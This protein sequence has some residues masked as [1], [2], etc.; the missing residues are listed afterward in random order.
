MGPEADDLE[1]ELQRN[2]KLRQEL[3]AEARL[4]LL[5]AR[6]AA[7]AEGH[8]VSS[9]PH[10][11]SASRVMR[12]GFDHGK[13]CWSSACCVHRHLADSTAPNQH[14]MTL[15]LGS[16]PEG[17][18]C[19]RLLPFSISLILPSWV[20][21]GPEGPRLIPFHPSVNQR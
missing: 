21:P 2:L 9:E 14:E 18:C 13:S 3:G 11:P 5:V 12:A 4:E 17:Y 16:R 10:A 15:S 20:E 7:A 1:W 8:A 6:G 19:N